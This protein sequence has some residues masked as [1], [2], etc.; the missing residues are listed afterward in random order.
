MANDM[1]RQ[2]KGPTSQRKKN[3]LAST[4]PNIKAKAAVHRANQSRMVRTED[5]SVVAKNYYDG[6]T[7][8]RKSGVQAAAQRRLNMHRSGPGV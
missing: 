7:I 2:P 3:P 1:P 8:R 5:G 4:D 6:P